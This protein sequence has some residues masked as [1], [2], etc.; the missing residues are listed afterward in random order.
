[1]EKCWE[2]FRDGLPPLSDSRDTVV[3]VVHA[4]NDGIG[5]NIPGKTEGHSEVFGAW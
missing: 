2:D 3:D 1:M 5:V 4:A